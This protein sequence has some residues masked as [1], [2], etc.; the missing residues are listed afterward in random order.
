[1]YLLFLQTVICNPDLGFVCLFSLNWPLNLV[2]MYI[3]LRVV[4]LSPPS[5]TGTERAGHFWWGYWVLSWQT[6]LLYIM[7]E[8]AGG[9]FVAVTVG[10]GDM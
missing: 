9:G 7:G 10:V 8:L 5:A 1:M 3:C 2:T 6:I 4:C